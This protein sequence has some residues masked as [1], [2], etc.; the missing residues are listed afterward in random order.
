MPI[1]RRALLTTGLL[2]GFIPR[3]HALAQSGEP[4]PVPESEAKKVAYKFQRREMAFKTQE[5]AG[6]IVVDTKRCFLYLVQGG[7]Q[8]T[9][10][11]VAVGKS[12]KAW[13]GEAVIKRMAKWPVWVPAPYHLEQI[14]SLAKHINGMPG[15]L[16]NPMGAR[17][18]YLYQGDVDTINRIH[19]SAKPSE[20]GSKKTAGCFG[21]LNIDIIHLY[22]RVAIGTRV[23]VLG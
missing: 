16:D 12:S 19:G 4:F 5:P 6:T 13:T 2:T 3:S 18:M 8:A 22:E 9:R 21:M 23:V 20:I 10:Y 14:P 15:G 17:A 1:T 7:G 11:G